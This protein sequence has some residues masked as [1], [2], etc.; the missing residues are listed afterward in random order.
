[1]VSVLPNSIIAFTRSSRMIT[2]ADSENKSLVYLNGLTTE[3]S[4]SLTA[5]VIKITAKEQS[6]T[7]ARNRTVIFALRT[8][9]SPV[10]ISKIRP[11]KAKRTQE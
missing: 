1:M 10:I 3:I 2:Q 11:L 8:L 6:A 7:V 5:S 9:A 4:H